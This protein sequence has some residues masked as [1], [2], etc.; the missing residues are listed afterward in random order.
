MIEAGLKAFSG[1]P[2]VVSCREKAYSLILVAISRTPRG[3]PKNLQPT[4]LFLE[5]NAFVRI[6]GSKERKAF[7]FKSLQRSHIGLCS[8]E[9]GS[10]RRTREGYVSV[11]GI[12][13]EATKYVTSKE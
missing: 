7:V 4:Y 2:R 9:M 6:E 8:E 13:L 11:G 1:D 3:N 10:C 5:F 12:R